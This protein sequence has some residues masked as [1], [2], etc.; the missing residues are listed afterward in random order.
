MVNRTIGRGCLALL[1]LLSGAEALAKLEL[2]V[3]R[4]PV[5]IDESF[6]L[7]LE[8]DGSSD[9]EPDFS[10]LQNSFEILNRST[11]S[12]FQMINGT[13][14]RTKRWQL[15]LIA[16]QS[17]ELTIPAISVGTQQSQ[18]VILN[19]NS[20]S[21]GSSAVPDENIF[22]E[23]TATPQ[24]LYVQQQLIYTV[25]IY[26]AIQ[27]A[28]GSALSEPKIEG[29][30][31]IIER[32][33]DDREFQTTRNGRRYA[34][35]ERRYAIY[36]QQSGTFT[37][38][39]LTFDA[40]IIER[41]RSNR[42]FLF[43]PFNQNTRRQRIRSEALPLEI[44]PVPAGVVADHWLPAAN[45]QL[46]E[47][48]PGSDPQS[49]PEFIVGEPVTRTLALLADGLTAAQL[50]A[51]G[52]ELP[53]GLKEYPEQPQL[54]DRK[55]ESGI[56]A[57]R[58]QK[59]ALIPTRAGRLTLPPIE[60]H[61]WNTTTN[62]MERATLPARTI[63][64]AAATVD[65]ASDLSVVDQPSIEQSAAESQAAHPLDSLPAS[66]LWP[67]LS[68]FLGVAW[69]LTALAWWRGRNTEKRAP[70][71]KAAANSQSL[72]QLERQLKRACQANQGTEAKQAILAWAKAY[73]K[74]STETTPNSLT[75]I[76][77][78]SDAALATA[79]NALDR[80]LYGTEQERWQG[81]DLWQ[82]FSHYT[83][84]LAS[85]PR[86]VRGRLAPL[87]PG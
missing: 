52:R 63:E 1:L 35:I 31:A 37:L 17:G 62:K 26:R 42:G 29:G 24:K 12:S 80:S 86:E 30:D 39:S 22:I 32:L 48:W 81:T 84:T 74:E 44:N 73:W 25:R 14:S 21:Q 13:T 18:A 65:E 68:L 49:V 11:N 8:S 85:N 56:T 54:K 53:E 70:I 87:H 51:L 78:R 83:T 20:P 47:Q 7:I 3:D 9:G 4:N 16:K 33:G 38:S 57:L 66:G 43:D 28:N 50:P 77:Q 60:L 67:W 59:I 46:L 82:A 34:V 27:L 64:V 58:Q 10:V 71:Q 5:T 41:Q 72:H 55:S 15:T 19:V 69:L 61:W 79:L 6:T 36:P 40:Q 45:L 23:V 75:A 76:G 2:Y